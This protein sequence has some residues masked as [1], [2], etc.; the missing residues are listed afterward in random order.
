VIAL[1]NE[2]LEIGAIFNTIGEVRITRGIF[3]NNKCRLFSGGSFLLDDCQ[4][5]VALD[6]KNVSIGPSCKINVSITYTS[7]FHEERPACA[8]APE[9]AS[10][11]FS[12]PGESDK[13]QKKRKTKI[14]ASIVAV[15]AVAIA[16]AIIGF[17]V[18]Q[19]RLRRWPKRP[20][21]A[22]SQD[23]QDD[24]S[25]HD[26]NRIRRVGRGT[27]RILELLEEVYAII[28]RQMDPF[29][30]DNVIISIIRRENPQWGKFQ[31]QPFELSDYGLV[32]RYNVPVFI[33]P[34]SN[35][36]GSD[37]SAPMECANLADDEDA[38]RHIDP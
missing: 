28:M 31:K 19:K 23:D 22:D 25:D 27:S 32:V 4:T 38:P 9:S 18:H 24:E 30:R 14:I 17:V 5:D 13:D 36:E 26:G 3:K 29:F 10:V 37:E 16:A 11:P 1:D 7:I 21:P 15:G 6:T 2:H 33:E 20:K 34:A 35:G 12:E 8:S